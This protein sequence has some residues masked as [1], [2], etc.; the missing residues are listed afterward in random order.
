MQNFFFNI[1]NFYVIRLLTILF[2][3]CEETREGANV[4]G[5]VSDLSPVFVE[6][7]VENDRLLLL[8]E[9]KY[10]SRLENSREI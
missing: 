4:V 1:S 6:W 8:V 10:I 3:E 7:T 9:N 5:K 2:S